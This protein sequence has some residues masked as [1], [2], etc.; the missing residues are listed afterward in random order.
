M[1]EF[2]DGNQKYCCALEEC[3]MENV[4]LVFV[5]DESKSVGE[6]DFMTGLNA[7]ADLATSLNIGAKV[8][9]S[10]VGFVLFGNNARLGF[11]L[12]QYNSVSEVE[13]AIKNLN[14]ESGGTNIAG[15][16]DFAI[17]QVFVPA[18]RKGVL[19]IMIL[20][21]DGEDSTN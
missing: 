7:A 9:S 11:S 13:N 3:Y 4:D 1:V 17:R 18:E 15:G 10:R 14:Y 8:N 21:T 16:M 12:T 5:M 6:R 2:H 20:I 19:K